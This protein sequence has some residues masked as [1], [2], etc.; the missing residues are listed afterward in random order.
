MKP[1]CLF[2]LIGISSSCAAPAAEYRESRQNAAAKE[3][4]VRANQEENWR[5]AQAKSQQREADERR[6]AQEELVQNSKDEEARRNSEASRAREQAVQQAS[7]E[8]EK[9]SAEG[10]RARAC[11][12]RQQIA[13]FDELIAREKRIGKKSGY[14]SPR[15]LHDATASKLDLQDE[16]KG[17]EAEHKKVTGKA[18]SS[19]ACSNGSL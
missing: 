14:V 7:L 9:H 6:R 16:L 3:E 18:L 13:E 1:Y 19:G 10:L 2:S 17:V 11:E 4:R 8:A 15:T 12:L 5:R